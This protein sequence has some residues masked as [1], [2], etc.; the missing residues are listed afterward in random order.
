[1]RPAV[2]ALYAAALSAGLVPA[3]ISKARRSGLTGLRLT[4]RLAL[5]HL[6]N[7]KPLWINA[8]SVGE[9]TVAEGLLRHL[10]RQ[11]PNLPVF[12]THS[13]EATRPLALAKLNLRA[14]AL[15]L[16]FRS[17][18]RRFLKRLQPRL[19]L[20]VE[21]ELWPNLI[22]EAHEAKVPVAVVNGRLPARTARRHARLHRCTKQMFEYLDLVVAQ[23]LPDAKRFRFLGAK[24]VT[25]SGNIKFDA[26]PDQAKVKAG[27]A[28]RQRL[29][30]A[31]PNLPVIL[32]ASTRPGTTGCGEEELLLKELTPKLGQCILILVPRHP[33]RF[34]EIARLLDKFKIQHARASTLTDTADLPACLLG[35]TMG[36]MDTYI[37]AADV[38]FIGASLVNRGGQNLME[39]MAQGKPI[40]IGPHTHNFARLT[41][42]A[43]RAGA[44]IQAADPKGIGT[45]LARLLAQ[46]H[47]QVAMGQAGLQLAQQAGGAI[48]RT[49]AT[50]QPLLARSGLLA[51]TTANRD[52]M[53]NALS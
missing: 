6:P 40:L 18:M 17:V 7:S 20:L 52:R 50:M 2:R 10:F 49:L 30:A 37:A 28:L 33:E 19:C 8:A 43:T 25:V 21:Q 11:Q 22:S 53:G 13:A 29:Q 14:H 1:M 44:A 41:Q 36:N 46:P 34:D 38:V 48:A 27:H 26:K 42:Q 39:A 15:P 35:D 47:N 16:D 45:A 32:L 5:A 24:Q 9:L 4:E 23:E 3:A 31:H 12:L 51:A